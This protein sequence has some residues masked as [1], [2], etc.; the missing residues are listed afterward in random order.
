MRKFVF[1]PFVIC[2]V[3]AVLVLVQPARGDAPKPLKSPIHMTYLPVPDEFRNAPATPEMTHTT[4]YSHVASSASAMP[5]SVQSVT[6]RDDTDADLSRGGR[7]S[8]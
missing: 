2:A 6:N 3:I 8:N 1:I 5:I 7:R 4:E